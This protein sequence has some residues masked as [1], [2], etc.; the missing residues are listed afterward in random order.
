MSAAPGGNP[1]CRAEFARALQADELT[2]MA[3]FS[4]FEN[5]RA[6]RK[7]KMRFMQRMTQSTAG[8]TPS[9]RG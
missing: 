2:L 3:P 5:Q 7:L 1:L 9:G 8:G 4:I 6:F